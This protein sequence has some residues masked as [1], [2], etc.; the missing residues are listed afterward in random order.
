MNFEVSNK[1]PFD[2]ANNTVKSV[3]TSTSEDSGI[4][5][6]PT[7]DK[8]TDV[9][10]KL[11]ELQD[12]YRDVMQQGVN[13]WKVLEQKLAEIDK[14]IRT[15]SFDTSKREEIDKKQN[16]LE[17][18]LTAKPPGME[19]DE[20]H[21]LQK[22]I[23]E[24]IEVLIVK[25]AKAEKIHNEEV[26]AL[27]NQKRIIT[28]KLQ[29][30]KETPQVMNAMA[31]EE[32]KELRD[33][34]R[35]MKVEIKDLENALKLMSNVAQPTEKAIKNQ[36][37]TTKIFGWFGLGIDNKILL[38]HSNP[39]NINLNDIKLYEK[40]MKKYFQPVYIRFYKAIEGQKEYHKENRS[41]YAMQWLDFYADRSKEIKER[42]DRKRKI[43]HEQEQRIDEI[44]AVKAV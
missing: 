33:R 9:S 23:N 31:L 34:I 1:N 27:E 21:A 26:L 7:L 39:A 19:E 24:T 36:M 13:D 17:Q 4:K 2:A 40:M 38:R 16:Q 30:I 6:I 3:E 8:N 22:E 5:H 44:A 42:I 10:Q 37:R 14:E 25:R 29:R 20:W 12:R 43:I 28:E 18:L 15:V 32:R 35:Q 11:K 41:Y